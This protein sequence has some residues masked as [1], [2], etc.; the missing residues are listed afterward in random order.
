[1][2]FADLGRKRTP[3]IRFRD[4]LKELVQTHDVVGYIDRAM[5]EAHGRLSGIDDVSNRLV[6]MI[7][8][9][10]ALISYDHESKIQRSAGLSSAG[11]HLLW[12]VW[13]TGPIG[14]SAVATLMGATRANVSG[15][16]ATLEKEGLIARVPSVE[17][18]R[19][20]LLT[21]T[22]EGKRRF[23]D[24][25]LKIG[26]HG[27]DMLSGFTTDELETLLRLL[28]RLAGVVASSVDR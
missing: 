25:W 7:F 12:V 3:T 16:S 24:T 14:G 23:E 4:E 11:F 21:L 19:S 1:M 27:K 18:G 2:G 22:P 5:T 26:D 13:L 8:R 6:L 9:I 20:H 17:D 15:V 10:G 28:G